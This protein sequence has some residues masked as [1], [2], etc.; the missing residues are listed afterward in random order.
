MAQQ[1]EF[2]LGGFKKHEHWG[3]M[4]VTDKI[5]CDIDLHLYG[6]ERH[7]SQRHCSTFPYLFELGEY[8]LNV[9]NCNKRVFVN[10]LEV[11]FIS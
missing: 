1:S 7:E 10:C 5:P 6:G 4:I 9:L 3:K 8:F 11:Y 2:R